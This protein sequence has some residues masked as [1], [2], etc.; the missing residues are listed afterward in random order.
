MPYVVSINDEFYIQSCLNYSCK[1]VN[2]RWRNFR[3]KCNF[4]FKF[5]FFVLSLGQKV[6][7]RCLQENV[8]KSGLSHWGLISNVK[9]F[10]TWS[11]RLC[12]KLTNAQ[13]VCLKS[14]GTSG[15]LTMFMVEFYLGLKPS[16]CCSDT[17]IICNTTRFVCFCFF[18]LSFCLYRV[19]G[20]KL[21]GAQL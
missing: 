14:S 19:P 13:I 6:F 21:S 5:F 11:S 17:I 9:S 1:K 4:T 15:V 3:S 7:A 20:K 8:S 10:H 2:G 16:V 12:P 18:F